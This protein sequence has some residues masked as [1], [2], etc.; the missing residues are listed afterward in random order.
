MTDV[1]KLSKVLFV[2]LY[3]DDT[4]IFWE[5]R[6]NQIIIE[7]NTELLKVKS[8]LVANRLILNVSKTHYMIFYPS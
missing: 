8:W 1:S 3:A 7:L 6:I 4:N 5:E 2:I